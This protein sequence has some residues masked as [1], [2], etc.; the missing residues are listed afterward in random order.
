MKLKL[1][2]EPQYFLNPDMVGITE[3]LVLSNESEEPIFKIGLDKINFKSF[4]IELSTKNEES[5]EIEGINVFIPNI[6]NKQILEISKFF[7]MTEEQVNEVKNVK[8]ATLA[9]SVEPDIIERYI[10]PLYDSHE[11]SKN[12]FQFVDEDNTIVLLD[13]QN[14]IVAGIQEEFDED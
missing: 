12:L 7:N 5:S 6:E 14:Y 3:R 2:E 9:F 13:F 4:E 10:Q 8:K 1:S 11:K